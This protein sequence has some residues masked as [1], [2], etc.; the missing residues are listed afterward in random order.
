MCE[1]YHFFQGDTFRSNF[2]AFFSCQSMNSSFFA[3]M[4][5]HRLLIFCQLFTRTSFGEQKCRNYNIAT[6][7][8]HF[9]HTAKG[10]C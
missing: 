1:S 9:M 6:T 3:A 2:P 7:V 10:S 4:K 8:E 5:K